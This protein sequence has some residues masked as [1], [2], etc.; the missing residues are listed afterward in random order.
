MT[1][2]GHRPIFLTTPLMIG[3]VIGGGTGAPRA[4]AFQNGSFEA[5]NPPPDST[6]G[7]SAPISASPR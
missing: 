6:S 4:A 2:F 3:G 7:R 5:N 1:N